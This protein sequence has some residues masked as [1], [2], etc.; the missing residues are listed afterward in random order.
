MRYNFPTVCERCERKCQIPKGK[1]WEHVLLFSLMVVSNDDD[2]DD[3]DSD[4]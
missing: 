1:H 3:D 2:D 4:V